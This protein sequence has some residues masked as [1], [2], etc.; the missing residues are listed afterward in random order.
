MYGR[1]PIES[2]EYHQKVME[3]SYG[4]VELHTLSGEAVEAQNLS[5]YYLS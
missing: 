3:S 4:V 5:V 2:C 1:T